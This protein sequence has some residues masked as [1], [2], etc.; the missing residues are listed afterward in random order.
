ML[1]YYHQLTNLSPRKILK[2][3]DQGLISSPKDGSIIE[4]AVPAYKAQHF[5]THDS[6][7]AKMVVKE[8]FELAELDN[9]VN[10]KGEPPKDCDLVANDGK[11]F[12]FYAPLCVCWI[13]KDR[14]PGIVHRRCPSWFVGQR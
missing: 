4:W 5:R 1:K 11:P 12:P 9:K 8:V 14:I 13:S 3:G 2:F 7:I 6:T 10:C